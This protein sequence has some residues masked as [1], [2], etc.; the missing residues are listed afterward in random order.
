MIY[1][2][3][4]ETIGR[5]PL[6]KINNT[7][8][9]MAEILVK[10][11]GFNPGGSIKDRP[12]LYMIKDAEEKGLLKKGDTIIEATSG[13][14]GIAL[15]MIGAALGYKVKIVM[16]D[17]MSIERRRIMTA[18]GAE[19]VLTEGKLGMQGSVDMAEKLAKENNYFLTRQF[20]NE[21]NTL[22][23]IET[24]AK[25]ILEDTD[26]KIDAFV[27]G[28]GTGGTISGIGKILKEHNKNILT[29]AVQPVK[30]PVLTG[31]APSGHG[32]QGIGA[33]FVP[34]I[35]NKDVVDEVLNMDEETAYEAARN[36]GK[37]EGILAGM[38]SGGNF[39]AAIE[40]AKRLGEGKRVVTV[41]P[42]TGERYL[43]TALF[44]QE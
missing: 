18:Y 44:E 20:A 17:T 12:A 16:P 8:K 26:G 33:N 3:I 41:L 32:I 24:T 2:N 22:S 13:N 4:S 28:V 37:N 42:D 27:A 40:I 43:S 14:M 9:G 35:Y 23:H 10:V 36:L 39:A 30:S 38:S 29:V 21:A 25:E 31:G 1:N 6:V 7:E 19:L 34:D 5:T 15:S 11:E